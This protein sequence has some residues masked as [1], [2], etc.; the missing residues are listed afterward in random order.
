M[1]VFDYAARWNID[2]ETSQEQY[3]QTSP[4]KVSVDR[5]PL[6]FGRVCRNWREI[7]LN[8]PEIW[9]RLCYCIRNTSLHR[10]ALE[11]VEQWLVL[12]AGKPLS[13]VIFAQHDITPQI[14]QPF[15][16]LY[17]QVLPRVETLRIWVSDNSFCGLP[18]APK[19][20]MPFCRMVETT[21]KNTAGIRWIAQLLDQ[22]PPLHSLIMREF[23][24]QADR[25]GLHLEPFLPCLSFLDVT[26]NNFCIRHVDILRSCSALVDA[27]LNFVMA[28]NE[29]ARDLN[30]ST[31]SFTLSQLRVLSI[32]VKQ[33]GEWRDI[34]AHANLPALEELTISGCIW[35][36]PTLVE[37]LQRS[38]NPLR[39][40]DLRDTNVTSGQLLEILPLGRFSLEILNVAHGSSRPWSNRAS[41]VECAV[42]DAVLNLLDPRV[43]GEAAM[44]FFHSLRIECWDL[45]NT[46]GKL[47]EVVRARM[48][49][50]LTV[51][52]RSLDINCPV[53]KT[54]E[55]N[56]QQM[57]FV[58]LLGVQKKFSELLITVHPPPL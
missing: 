21:F 29:T 14:L 51:N 52:M 11:G 45:A 36:L 56:P 9:T 27:R 58:G 37:C 16:E 30:T 42:N 39:K 12:S 49:S 46:L 25:T 33:P 41:Q 4:H 7:S 3:D 48:E 19:Q 47:T 31:Q 13:L 15:I 2:P 53:V 57:E 22:S 1:S 10:G 18:P 55:R 50:E 26:I 23:S 43:S 6:V 5:P 34:F 40:L 24:V 32:R 20:A 54:G 17:Y 28:G 44:P 35:P 8:C 38:E